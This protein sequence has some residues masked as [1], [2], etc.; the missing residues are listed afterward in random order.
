MKFNRLFSLGI[1]VSMV[2][3]STAAH[4]RADDDQDA[5]VKKRVQI[6]VIGDNDEHQNIERHVLFVPQSGGDHWIGVYA[7][8]A[9]A[10]LKSHLG[11]E[12]RLIVEQVIDDSPAKKAGVQ[13]HDILLK[14]GDASITTVEDL[15][16][17]VSAAKDKES[18]LSL[19]RGGK[20]MSVKVTAAKRPENKLGLHIE[21]DGEHLGADVHGL[22]GKWIHEH[23]AGDNSSGPFK[24]RVIGPGVIDPKFDVKALHEALS[25]VHGKMPKNLSIQINKTGDTAAKIKVT[26]DGKTWEV[27][28]ENLEKLPENVRAHVKRTLGGEHGR[29]EISFGPGGH[30]MRLK[31]L[32]VFRGLGN[33]ARAIEIHPGVPAHGTARIL[34]RQ[35][36]TDSDEV[37]EQLRKDVD[38]LKAAFKKLQAKKSKKDDN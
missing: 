4:V 19:I 2:L 16:K 12:D 14:Y 15:L 7:V 18:S 21:R 22:I 32:Q 13:R 23:A 11:I 1:I 30:E 31:A 25:G 20:K 29:V 35:E 37:V 24:L 10:A 28:E 9:G 6:F 34:I 33:N 26:L 36:S 17:A 8:P 3:L 27:T 5:D 38:A